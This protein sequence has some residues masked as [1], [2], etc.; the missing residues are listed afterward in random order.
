[1][2]RTIPVL[3]ASLISALAAVAQ[4]A[5]A[6]R[7]MTVDDYFQLRQVSDPQIAPDGSAVVYVVSAA[8]FDRARWDTD[9]WRVRPGA[10]PE[11][12]TFHPG[13][14]N[15]PR[16]SPGGK[17]IAFLRARPDA[18]QPAA[19]IFLLE[20]DGGEA[21]ALTSEPAGVN[22]FAWAPDGKSIFYLAAERPPAPREAPR[23]PEPQ[24][25]DEGRPF[26]RLWRIEIAGAQKSRI[27]TG[28]QHVREFAL[29]P[30][31]RRLIFSAA[32]TPYFNDVLQ[33][34]L[35]LLAL[36]GAAAPRRLTEN[37]FPEGGIA[38]RPDGS[39]FSFVAGA[40]AGFT[41][42]TFQGSAFY[43]DLA[44]GK[45]ERLPVTTAVA[46]QERFTGDIASAEWADNNVLLVVAGSGTNQHLYLYDFARQRTRVITSGQQV[47]GSPSVARDGRIAFLRQSPARPNDV[48]LVAPGGEPRPLTEHN[49]QVSE[50]ALPN[51]EVVRW[52]ASDGADVEGILLTPASGDKPW[53]LVTRIHGGPASAD[54]AGFQSAAYVLTGAGFAVFLPNYR[55]STNYGEDFAAR[56]I[57]DRNGRDARD[58]E[59]GI[60]ALIA[61]GIAD[62]ER[63]GVG[64]W[65]AGGVLT[66]W[67][68]AT[69]P[70]YRAASSGAGVADWTM[71][72]FLSDYTWGSELYFEGTPWERKELYWT[73]SP[74]R[75]AA[76]VK[77]PTL[78][79]C[80]AN[81]ERVPIAHA[82]SWFRALRAHG[83][84][85]RFVV[86]PGEPHSLQQP[87]NQRRRME[88][89]LNWYRRF[90]LGAQAAAE[91]SND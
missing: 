66:N 61:R 81:D 58:I 28:P 37:S 9:L 86:Y 22:S 8:D 45:V 53:P 10:A 4:T 13:R 57:G 89:D 1:M 7:G 44:A 73:R 35:F 27:D 38:W 25:E 19:Q 70:R 75:L 88:E 30:D 2:R 64:G 46:L 63:L 43:Y 91:K 87:A 42:R 90:L 5:P 29:S 32:P 23:R 56:S 80:G 76:Q 84:E 54:L 79:H 50:L 21:R 31:G 52:R 14:D 68:I 59:E 47:A 26:A 69:N 83:V 67:L 71:Q 24:V 20:A 51:Y 36:D 41:Q 85:T 17:T 78:I 49:P 77:T 48:W 12:L 11:R 16:W 62:P 55:G 6:R 3:L 39:G 74:L 18:G 34:E 60:D 15:S 33:S 40:D 65:S 82:R 72:Y